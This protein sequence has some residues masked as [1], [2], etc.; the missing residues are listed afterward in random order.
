MT[1]PLQGIDHHVIGDDIELFLCLALHILGICR[2]ENANQTA[3]VHGAGYFFTGSQYIVEQRGEITSGTGDMA[4]LLD[5][6][7]G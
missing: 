4:L 2:A 1:S 7:L 5:N 6:E 3:A